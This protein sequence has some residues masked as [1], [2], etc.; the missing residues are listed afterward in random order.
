M[1]PEAP[2]DVGGDPGI[3]GTVGAFDEVQVPGV[4]GHDISKY[5]DLALAK[6]KATEAFFI[7][8]P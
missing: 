1:L 5:K 4:F 7:G 8:F 6:L 3:E 2:R